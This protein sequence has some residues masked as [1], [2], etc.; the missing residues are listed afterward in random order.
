M[1]SPLVLFAII[2]QMYWLVDLY[3][4]QVP[5]SISSAV[6]CAW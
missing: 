1:D 4:Y 3:L 5:D 6:N 2:G